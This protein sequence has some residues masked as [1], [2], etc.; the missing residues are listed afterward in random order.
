MPD[1]HRLPPVVQFI[2]ANLSLDVGTNPGNSNDHMILPASLPQH[3]AYT[4]LIKNLS[5]KIH[6]KN[7]I[8]A[9]KV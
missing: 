2:P 4:Q 8:F 3:L 1:A 5:L 7:S 6:K 9:K